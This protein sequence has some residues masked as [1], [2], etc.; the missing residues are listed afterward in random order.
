MDWDKPI[1]EDFTTFRSKGLGSSD[2]P[3]ILGV[4]PWK[5]PY[6]LWQEKTGIIKN[7][8]KGNWATR[9]GTELEPMVRA[10]YNNEHSTAMIPERTIH[11]EHDYL[12]ANADGVDHGAKRM[13]EIK[14]G[15]I[16]DHKARK[17]P[18]KY[19]PQVMF[20]SYVFGY[21]IDYVSY[22]KGL[23]ESPFIVIPVKP[24]SEFTEMMLKKAHAFWHMV[25]EKKWKH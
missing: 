4:S 19:Y 6:T 22:N 9:R 1:E 7:E 25:K 13:I 10:W 15:N 16:K 23:K 5:K 17:V 11:S 20:L 3:V 14:C 21:E 2:M 8:F 18:E 12:R 24:D